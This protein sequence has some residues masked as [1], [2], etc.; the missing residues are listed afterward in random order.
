MKKITIILI[1]TLY[2]ITSIFAQKES[3]VFTFDNFEF[4]FLT[5]QP[6][7]RPATVSQKDYDWGLF[8]LGEARKDV[9]A[10][11][12]NYSYSDFWNITMAFMRLG[13]PKASVEVA[14]QKAIAEH[15]QSICEYIESFG[16]KSVQSLTAA[17]PEVFLPFYENC[18]KE[19]VAVEKFDAP[20]YAAENNLDLALIEQ[21]YKISETDQQYR[22]E[23][24]VDWSKQTPLD[25]ANLATIEKLYQ[26]YG[27][28]LGE[29]LVGEKLK[30]VMW[31]VIQHSNIETM[32]MY[33]PIIHQAVKKGELPQVPLKMLL[34]RIHCHRY[35]YQAFGSQ[36]GSGCPLAT[37]E[38]Q[39]EI[40][41]EYGIK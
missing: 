11:G 3:P 24:P 31:L 33:L 19:K 18:G 9:E 41:K 22:S 12:M 2:A 20:K 37:K 10:D 34:D 5:Y 6:K 17:I 30:E 32:E 4:E 38:K 16:E 7:P 40:R 39:A 21:I 8:V 25:E 14:F 1:I 35:N 28:Y 15:P 26:Q 36:Y 13:E 29:S 23:T 27:T